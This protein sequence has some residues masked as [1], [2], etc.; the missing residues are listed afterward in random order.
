MKE[1]LKQSFSISS[2]RK[3]GRDLC[4]NSEETPKGII[5]EERMGITGQILGEISEGI[6]REM[7]KGIPEGVSE[8]SQSSSVREC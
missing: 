7:P 8:E 4:K 5:E 2:T 6:P 3:P 1:T